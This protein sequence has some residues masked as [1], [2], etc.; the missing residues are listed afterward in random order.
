MAH[1]NFSRSVLE[2]TDEMGTSFYDMPKTVR[3]IINQRETM[4]LGYTKARRTLL[5]HATVMR[6]SI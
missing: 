2:N 6:G 4:V 5:H 1:T 3:Y